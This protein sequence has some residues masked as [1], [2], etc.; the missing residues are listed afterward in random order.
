M[1]Y[2]PLAGVHFT[3]NKWHPAVT[4]ARGC[5]IGHGAK[6]SLTRRPKAFDIASDSLSFGSRAAECLVQQVLNGQ[7]H[8]ATLGLQ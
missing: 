2:A 6:L 7:K 8:F 1:N 4:H 5:E 3:E